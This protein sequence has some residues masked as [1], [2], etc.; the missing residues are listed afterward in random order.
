MGGGRAF[1]AKMESTVTLPR[2][3]VGHATKGGG[4]GGGGGG[5]GGDCQK[6]RASIPHSSPSH[7]FSSPLFR[8]G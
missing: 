5:R 7:M 2:S 3:R 8:H 6:R 1:S 4:G